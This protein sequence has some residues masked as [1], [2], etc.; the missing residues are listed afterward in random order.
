M[1]VCVHGVMQVPVA[2]M[3]KSSQHTACTIPNRP[4]EGASVGSQGGDFARCPASFRD[5]VGE[6]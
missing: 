6:M 3:P 4:L 1:C 2:C 5:H